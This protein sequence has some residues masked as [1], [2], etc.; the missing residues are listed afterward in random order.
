MAADDGGDVEA[1]LA[2]LAESPTPLRWRALFEERLVCVLAADHPVTSAR[3]SVAELA[4][5][6]HASVVVLGTERMLVETRL[7]TLGIPPRPGLRVPS[8]TAALTALPG[9]ELIAVLPSRVLAG[10]AQTGLRVAAAP[11]EFDEFGYGM[12]W[13]PRLDTDPLHGWLR[14]LVVDACLELPDLGVSSLLETCFDRGR[15]WPVRSG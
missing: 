5:Y 15:K 2:E 7:A 9:T 3:L 13:H 10:Q 1:E 12:S 8:F 6:P 11:R 14:D 4:R